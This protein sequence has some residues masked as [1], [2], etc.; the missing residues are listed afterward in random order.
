MNEN[1]SKKGASFIFIDGAFQAI[2]ERTVKL[3]YDGQDAER[4]NILAPPDE[5]LPTHMVISPNPLNIHWQP[6]F[7]VLPVFVLRKFYGFS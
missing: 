3:V 7:V 5:R 4:I 1:T 6:F 2:Y